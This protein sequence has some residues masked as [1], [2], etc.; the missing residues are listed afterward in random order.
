VLASASGPSDVPLAANVVGQPAHGALTLD[1]DGSFTYM[2]ASGYFGG[3]SFTYRAGDPSGNY[4]TAQ[5]TLTVAAPPSASISTPPGGGTYTVGQAVSTAFSCSEGAGGTGL[6]SCAD[7]TGAKTKSGGV[8]SLDTSI[9]GLHAYTVTAV[10]Q[11]GLTSSA[12]TSYTVV[13]APPNDPGEP[14]NRPPND[15]KGP[16]RK[17]ELSLSVERESLLEL[18]RTQK[19][20]VAATVNEAATL[21]LAGSARLKIHVRGKMRT[22]PVA[23]FKEKTVGFVE[24]DE[25]KVTLVLS[26]RGRETL[27]RLSR[28][29]LMI[30]GQATN[31]AGEPVRRTVALTLER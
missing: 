12:S 5:V 31:P 7:S 20:V 30:A 8:G 11:D 9:V 4:A 21:A 29:R 17:F 15:P 24:P 23:L 3:D 26:R 13:P 18:L 2:P 22:Q 1:D 19:L 16:P 25:Q 28:L 10:S 14:P 27:R 6:S